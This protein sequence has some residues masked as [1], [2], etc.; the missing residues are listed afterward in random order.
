[1]EDVKAEISGLIVSTKQLLDGQKDHENRL[2][3][4]ELFLAVVFG[5]LGIYKWFIGFPPAG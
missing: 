3:R 4:L 5:A 1:M 2:R